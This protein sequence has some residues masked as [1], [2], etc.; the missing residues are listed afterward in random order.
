MSERIR[1][2]SEKLATS[3]S[4]KIR[5]TVFLA[6]DLRILLHLRAQNRHFSISKTIEEILSPVI[7]RVSSA[8]SIEQTAILLQSRARIQQKYDDY[9]RMYSPKNEGEKLYGPHPFMGV[10]WVLSRSFIRSINGMAALVNVSAEDL[11]SDMLSEAMPRN[12]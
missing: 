8:S 10:H 9:D 2:I 4:R 3:D 11:M 6:E 5:G 12:N 7:L 1:S